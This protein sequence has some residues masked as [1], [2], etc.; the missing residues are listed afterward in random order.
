MDK[1]ID[2]GFCVAR[3]KRQYQ[4]NEYSLQILQPSECA[5]G[6]GFEPAQSVRVYGNEELKKLRDALTEVL[7]ESSKKM[8]TCGVIDIPHSDWCDCA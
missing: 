3:I 2:L 4:S 5:E 8:C 1:V 7:G 6:F